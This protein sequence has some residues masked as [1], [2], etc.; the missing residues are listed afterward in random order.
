MTIFALLPSPLLGSAAWSAVAMELRDRDHE[1]LEIPNPDTPPHS[2][3]QYLNHLLEATPSGPEYALVPHSNAGLYVPQLAE[4]RN[5]ANAVFVDA[6]VPPAAGKVPVAPAGMVETLASMASRDGI[7]PPWT[8]WWS[9][10]D[11]AALYPNRA[12]YEYLDSQAP[13]VPLSYFR[14]SIEVSEGWSQLPGTFL[15]FGDT[16]RDTQLRAEEWGWPTA[17]MPGRH[18]HMLHDPVAV[19]GQILH[20]N[21]SAGAS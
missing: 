8:Q 14:H 20:L 12:V 9:D 2:P 13:H 15:G 11:T 10:T 17:T 5:V 16:Y 18:L 4:V 1:V 21:R 6:L 7:L 19:A 3:A